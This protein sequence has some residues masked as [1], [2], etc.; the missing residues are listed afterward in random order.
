MTNNINRVKGIKISKDNL[1]LIKSV[2]FGHHFDRETARGHKYVIM[3][4]DGKSL[5]ADTKKAIM[6]FARIR[7]SRG[8]DVASCLQAKADYIEL[9]R[10]LRA[11]H[12]QDIEHNS[13]VR[14]LQAGYLLQVDVLSN[15]KGFVLCTLETGQVVRVPMSDLTDNRKYKILG[16]E[17][18]GVF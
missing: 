9:K 11:I 15:R 17:E 1:R 3:F 18:S 4:W 2:N 7:G 16:N 5:A 10:R 6:D 8:E 12:H 13:F 14:C